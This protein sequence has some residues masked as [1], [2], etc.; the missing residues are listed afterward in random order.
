MRDF[1]SLTLQL[2]VATNLIMWY[3]CVNSDTTHLQLGFQ[4][5]RRMQYSLTCFDGSALMGFIPL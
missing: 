4:V 5:K 2:L 3:A 1:E